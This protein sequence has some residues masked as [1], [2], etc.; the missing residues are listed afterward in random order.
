MLYLER[1]IMQINQFGR[2]MVEMLG[3][4]AIIGVLSVGSIAGYQKA[5]MKYRIN[6]HATSFNML[7]SNALQLSGSIDAS[8]EGFI[9]Y[10]DLINKAKMIPDDIV[11]KSE[12]WKGGNKN[13]T[14]VY[15]SPDRLEDKFGSSITFFS[16]YGFNY[17]FAISYQ[18]SNTSYSSAICQNIINIAKEHSSNIQRLLREDVSGS[19][20][21]SSSIWSDC[22]DNDVCFNKLSV[23]DI[24]N[25]CRIDKDNKSG[26]YL[27]FILW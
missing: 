10:N 16:R 19:Y 20:W 1:K 4:L 18:L 7:L 6:K 15:N 22:K 11:Y 13:G 27:F 26:N 9:F 2:S 17:N 25:M 12:S 8:K 24:T 23:T 3:V 14:F 5:M 21:K